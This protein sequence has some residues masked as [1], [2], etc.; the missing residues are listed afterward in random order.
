MDL[1]ATQNSM[2]ANP[3]DPWSRH[4]GVFSIKTPGGQLPRS[5]G[6]ATIEFSSTQNSTVANPTDPWG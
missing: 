3:T 5:V 1:V 6:L 2:V 4:H